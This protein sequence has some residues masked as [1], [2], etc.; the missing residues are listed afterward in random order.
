MAGRGAR[1][2][3]AHP[4]TA[5]VT[6][7]VFRSPVVRVIYGAFAGFCVWELIQTG[8]AMVDSVPRTVVGIAASC[9]ILSLFLIP[10]GAGLVGAF[11][12]T[13]LRYGWWDDELRVVSRLMLARV[14]LTRDEVRLAPERLPLQLTGRRG[15]PRWRDA[16]G[17][18]VPVMCADPG[19]AERLLAAS[20][21]GP[22]ERTTKQR[23]TR[24]P[25]GG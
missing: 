4:Q 22:L 10:L 3:R 20:A 6:E 11:G 23:V 16:L 8:F 12:R 17:A 25:D 2:T 19:N 14:P 1:P 5:E 13:Q 18:Q 21:Q 15:R 7:P 9:A 24:D